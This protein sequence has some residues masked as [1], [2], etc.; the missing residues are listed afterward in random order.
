MSLPMR[1]VLHFDSSREKYRCD[2]SV[3][4]CFDNRFDAVSRKLL[5]R[6]GVVQPDGIRIA[7]GAK[8]LASPDEEFNRSFVLE[9]IRKSIRLHGTERAILMLHSDCG[10]YGGL[11]ARFRGDAE[12]EAAHHRAELARAAEVLKAAIPG[13]AV[14]CFFLNFDGAWV[15][16]QDPGG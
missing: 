4:S 12:A 1:K 10:A 6:L 9:Q 13:L 16:E 3:V 14:E 8:A 15:V 7:G 2:A 5:R 11:A